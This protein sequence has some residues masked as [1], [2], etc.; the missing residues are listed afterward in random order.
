MPLAAE[1]HCQYIAEWVGTK[2]RWILTA[3]EPEMAA[4]HR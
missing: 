3:D 2:L 4:L 1:V